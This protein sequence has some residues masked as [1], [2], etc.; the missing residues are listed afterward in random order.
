MKI[1]RELKAGGVGVMSTAAKDGTVNGAVYALPHRIDERT[2]AWGMTDRQTYRNVREN[3]HAFFTY[4]APGPGYTGVRLSLRLREVRESGE[5]LDR[6]R[7]R[8]RESVGDA[9]AAAVKY[10]VFF[11][12]V[13]ERPLV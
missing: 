10:A 8:T 12:V 5:V 4:V 11:T 1:L 2:V 7:E 6:I 3:P 13:D 9:A